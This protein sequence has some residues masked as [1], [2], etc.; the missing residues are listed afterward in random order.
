MPNCQRCHRPAQFK[1]TLGTG[2]D[3][4]VRFACVWHLGQVRY[5]EVYDPTQVAPPAQ[6]ERLS[7]EKK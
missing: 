1:V 7:Q 3:T 4:E 5:G 6:V 2:D